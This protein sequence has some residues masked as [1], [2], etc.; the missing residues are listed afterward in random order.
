MVTS[1]LFRLIRRCWAA[2]A[3]VVAM[4]ALPAFAPAHAVLESSTPTRGAV[5]KEAPKEVTFEFNE[6]VEASFGAVRVFDTDGNQ[7]QTGELF[8][9]GG[10]TPDLGAC[11]PAA[12]GGGV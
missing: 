3:V 5:L 7:V 4:L 6:A 10:Q 1:R 11:R 2:L 9:P 12:E 8:R